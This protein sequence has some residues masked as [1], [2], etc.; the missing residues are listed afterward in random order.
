MAQSPLRL[1]RYFFNKI[2]CEADLDYE[3]P[4]LGSDVKYEVKVRSHAASRKENKRDWVVILDI[5]VFTNEKP[6]PYEIDLQVTGFFDVLPDFPNDNV[7]DLIQITGASILYSA[8][9]EF[10]LGITSRGPWEPVLLPAISFMK[11]DQQEEPKPKRT[12]K[13][14]SNP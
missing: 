10:V 4:D 13:T 8:A 1:S 12:R 3:G 14:K 7:N 5:H 2:R 9:R 11:P 6:G